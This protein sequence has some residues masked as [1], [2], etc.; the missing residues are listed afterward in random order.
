MVLAACATTVHGTRT[1]DLAT[2]KITA[3]ARASAPQGV[4]GEQLISPDG[5]RVI[6]KNGGKLCV[7]DLDGTHEVCTAAKVGADLRD[8]AWSPDSKHVAFTDD[9]FRLFVEPDVWVVDATT[10]EATDLTDD[11]VT[12][13]GFQPNPKGEYDLYPSWSQDGR[14]IR[15]AR[16]AGTSR[17]STVLIESV[18]AGGGSVSQLGT[19]SGQ[20]IELAGLAFSPDGK[21]VAWSSGNSGWETSTVH[22]RRVGGGTDHALSDAPMKGDQSLLSFSPDGRYLLVDDASTYAAYACCP[23]STARVYPSGGGAGQQIATNAIYPTWSPTGH[24]LAFATPARPKATLQ[25]VADPGGTP[26]TIGSSGPY[27]A[28]DGRRLQWTDAGL[29]GYAGSEPA[30]LRL[31]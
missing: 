25:V 31:S 7:F 29:F 27:G 9:Y 15:F 8:A 11:G 18:P 28:A 5:R 22:I 21:T 14:S 10:G 23:S 13:G 19:I 26:R 20:L 24:G 16:Q 6:G 2:L 17:G 12:G 30:L 4:S 3:T 1:L